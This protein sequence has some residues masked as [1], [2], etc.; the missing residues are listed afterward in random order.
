MSSI[1]V[2]EDEMSA[3]LTELE[4]CLQELW[5]EIRET[6]QSLDVRLA[7]R[8]RSESFKSAI[9][10]SIAG[11]TNFTWE[12]TSVFHDPSLLDA[13]AIYRL[14]GKVTCD[15][16]CGSF[17]KANLVLCLNNRESIG[18]NFLKLETAAQEDIRNHKALEIF[19]KNILGILISFNEG[20]LRE[21]SW[22]SSY[23]NADEYTFAYK[24]AYKGLIE[25]NIIGMQLHLI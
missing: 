17:H 6:F 12:K 8:Q 23:G 14:D 7:I 16:S 5:A 15:E 2:I 13:A 18:T 22:D 4:P 20:L 25:S 9:S 10:T 1:K 24:H 11:K 19:D 3:K 21:G